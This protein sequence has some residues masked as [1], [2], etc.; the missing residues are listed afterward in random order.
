VRIVIADD[1]MLVRAGLASVLRDA[2]H[3]VLAE[4]S[5][6]EDLLREVDAHE[7]DVAVADIRMPPTHTDEGLRAAREIRARHPGIGIVIVSQHVEAGVA[8]RLLA[9]SPER[10]GYLLKERITDPDEFV[11]TLRRVAAGGSALD[12]RIVSELLSN[13]RNDGPLDTLTPRE[14]EVLELMAQGASNQAI[15]DRLAI[16]LRSTEKYVSSIFTK[17]G[18]SSSGSEHRRVLAVLRFLDG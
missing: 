4:A 18:L 1:N 3:E 6:G 10:L 15:A 2:G 14:R 13:P 5:S 9:E 17:F 11:E 7:P 16:T 12:P 8:T